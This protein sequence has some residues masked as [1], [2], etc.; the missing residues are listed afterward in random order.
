MIGEVRGSEA[1]LRRIID[2]IP[3]ALA[4]CN[5]AHGS[6]E[7]LNRRWHDYYGSDT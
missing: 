3:P 1:Q 5:S 6:N 2:T 4:W 7:F